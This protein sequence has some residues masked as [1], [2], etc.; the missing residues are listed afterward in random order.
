LTPL[1]FRPF[2]SWP[3]SVIPLITNPLV[4]SGPKNNIHFYPSLK[5]RFKTMKQ[6]IVVVAIALLT[7]PYYIPTKN[8]QVCSRTPWPFS[9]LHLD[10]PLSVDL[11]ILPTVHA[12]V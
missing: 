5:T 2:S 7:T 3:L 4:I 9:M 12:M 6:I 8:I 1:L 11:Y 10:V